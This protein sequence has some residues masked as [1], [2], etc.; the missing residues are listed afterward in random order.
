MKKIAGF[1]GLIGIRP[2]LPKTGWIFVHPQSEPESESEIA[3]STYYVPESDE[4]EAYGEEHLSAWLE[5]PT[6]LAILDVR[7][8]GGRSPSMNQYI[9][10][11]VYYLEEDGFLE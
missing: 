2:Q 7:D 9:D 1:A 6:F 4:D 3:T 5:A 10:A 11:V 8:K